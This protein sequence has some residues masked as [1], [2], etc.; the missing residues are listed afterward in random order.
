M[1]L[2]SVIIDDEPKCCN[3]I[4]RLILKYIPDV[5]VLGKVHNVEDGI[6]EIQSKRPD[7]V[8]L[9]IEMPGGGGFTLLEKIRNTN[10]MVI[11]TTAYD[12]YAIK[13]IEYSALHYLLKPVDLLQL[14][15]A[16]AKAVN[17]KIM[18]YQQKQLEMLL[19]NIKNS[20]GKFDKIALNVSDGIIFVNPSDILYCKAEGAYTNF[21]MLNGDKHEVS[22]SLVNYEK[23]L[24]NDIF[25]RI[26]NSYL[27]NINFISRYLNK[28]GGFVILE[29]NEK[30]PV[31]DSKKAEFKMRMEKKN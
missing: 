4:E 2:T 25:Y 6:S 7:I 16:V 14:K 10:F 30:I 20:N 23:L 12:K 22:K 11:F 19:S 15:K 17:K 26:H 27:V 29:N 18:T 3:D 1:K 24:P 9:D 21:F 13:A 5:S 31:A 8:F 28:D